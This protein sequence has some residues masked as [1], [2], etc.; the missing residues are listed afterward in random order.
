MW[1]KWDSQ[2]FSLEVSSTFQRNW[3]GT[4][5]VWKCCHFTAKRKENI[6]FVS[7]LFNSDNK[8]KKEA[9]DSEQNFYPWI[10]TALSCAT[11][12]RAR[13]RAKGEETKNLL[14]ALRKREARTWNFTSKMMLGKTANIFKVQL[15]KM[16]NICPPYCK[17]C[18]E[19]QK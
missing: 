6:Q 16:E 17:H 3:R 10:K 1:G 8:V 4:W 7:R 15:P 19:L 13:W 12:T 11:G 5:N 2:G 18:Y 14:Y 9:S